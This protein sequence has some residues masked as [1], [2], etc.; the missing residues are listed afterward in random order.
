MVKFNII[1]LENEISIDEYMEK[2]ND[3]EKFLGYCEA[4]P[5]YSKTWSCP[6][7]D[8]NVEDF[9]KEYKNLK[10]I[11]KKI[12]ISESE[13]ERGMEIQTD[14]SDDK[15]NRDIENKIG[16]IEADKQVG[17]ENKAKEA[18]A[19][20]KKYSEDIEIKKEMIKKELEY[21]KKSVLGELLELEKQDPNIRALS[22][23]RCTE[24]EIC[25]R[26]EGKDCRNKDKMRY[27]IEALGGDV[28]GITQD[29]LHHEI[30]WS[31]GNEIPEYFILVGGLLSK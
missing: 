29:L 2:Y 27:S 6:P 31:K 21:Q 22:M 23:G 13:N 30:K 28:V 12:E 25:T 24:C 10:I 9:L 14:I 26:Q 8:F 16:K 18:K 17:V 19:I 11:G 5:N 4:C 1:E 20:E 15:I 3:V 7:F